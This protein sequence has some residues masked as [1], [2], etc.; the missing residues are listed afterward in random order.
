LRVDPADGND[1]ITV[2]RTRLLDEK[3]LIQQIAKIDQALHLWELIKAESADTGEGL[4][5]ASGEVRE[6]GREAGGG[7][8]AD[9]RAN[10]FKMIPGTLHG[11]STLRGYFEC[12]FCPFSNLSSEVCWRN[13][14]FGNPS[15]LEVG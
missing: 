10:C 15:L 7:G 11:G 3:Y 5:S 2:S 9:T 12:V 4:G 14:G 6:E 8:G 1:A 13:V